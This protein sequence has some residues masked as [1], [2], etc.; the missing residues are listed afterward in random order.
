[1][2]DRAQGSVAQPVLEPNM[3]DP[4]GFY[5]QFLAAHEGLGTEESFELNVRLLM[6]LA[7]QVRDRHILAQCIEIAATSGGSRSAGG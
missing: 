2:N 1:M 5:E 7:N 3:E 6:L 4:D